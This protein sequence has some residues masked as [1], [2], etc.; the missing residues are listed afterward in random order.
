MAGAAHMASGGQTD[1]QRTAVFAPPPELWGLA[2]ITDHVL[3]HLCGYEPNTD[4]DSYAGRANI[5]SV[6]EAW[7]SLRDMAASGHPLRIETVAAAVHEGWATT[8]RQVWDTTG[9][10]GYVCLRSVFHRCV[11]LLTTQPHPPPP[12]TTPPPAAL[13]PSSSPGT[14][15]P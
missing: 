5:A 1:A 10:V 13:P 3:S 8:A 14:A 6:R 15:R 9:C 2:C 7:R 12:T 4:P 11:G